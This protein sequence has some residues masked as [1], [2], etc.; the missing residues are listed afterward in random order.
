MYV[1]M[2]VVGGDHAT[3]SGQVRATKAEKKRKALAMTVE[4]RSYD[5][6][7]EA[8]KEEIRPYTYTYIHTYIHTYSV[9]YSYLR[10][11]YIHTYIHT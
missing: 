11:T 8:L 5:E 9:P 2:Y 4:C 6:M 7:L 10:N 1:C 3:S